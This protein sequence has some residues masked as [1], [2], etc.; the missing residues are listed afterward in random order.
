M[1]IQIKDFAKYLFN[2]DDK[3]VN[4]PEETIKLLQEQGFS[5]LESLEQSDKLVKKIK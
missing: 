2:R 1:K 5:E 3:T 4:I